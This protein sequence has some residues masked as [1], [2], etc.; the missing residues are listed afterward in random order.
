MPQGGAIVLQSSQAAGAG[1]GALHLFDR[2]VI[3]W[4]SRLH[5]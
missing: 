1:L 2:K 5:S 3:Q 4:K